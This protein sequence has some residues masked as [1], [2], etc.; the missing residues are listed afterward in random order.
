MH[1]QQLVGDHAPTF[2]AGDDDAVV[3]QHAHQFLDEIRNALGAAGE[4]VAQRS[5]HG[6]EPAQQGVG[7]FAATALRQRCQVD[8]LVVRLAAAPQRAVLEQRRAGQTQHHH[9]HVAARLGKVVDE[10]E[11]ALVGPVQVVQQERDR[12]AVALVQQPEVLGQRVERTVAQLPGIVGDAGDVRAVAVVEADQVADQCRLLGGALAEPRAQPL[13]EL[14]LSHGLG[15]A[16]EDLE[17]PGEKV[18]QQ[19]V[20]HVV[21]IR[22]GAALEEHH[23]PRAQCQPV[24]E[25]EQQAALADAGVTDHRRQRQAAFLDRALERINQ[26]GEFQLAAHHAGLDALDA[27]VRHPER[28]GFG[29]VHEVAAH[30]LGNALD[31]DRRLLRDIEHP[32]HMAVGIVAD[33]QGTGWRRLLHPRRDVDGDAADAALGVDAAAEQHRAGVDAD[34]KVEAR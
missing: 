8:A 33:A 7:E 5:G 29:A 15:V 14:G 34:P 11:R 24:A 27:P 2:R 16:I 19:A 12:R 4:Q 32:A 3:D 30:R 28:P 13:R 22:S 17:A 1:G 25:L 31:R 21:A 9:G 18:A 6:F 26:L 20:G 23:G 10:V